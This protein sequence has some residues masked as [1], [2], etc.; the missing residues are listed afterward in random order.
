MAASAPWPAEMMACE[1]PVPPPVKELLGPHRSE[2]GIEPGGS[3]PQSPVQGPQGYRSESCRCEQVD[4]DEA[5]PLAHEP[6]PLDEPQQFL[7]SFF[8]GGGQRLKQR[9]EFRAIPQV[10]AG[11]LPDDEGVPATSASVSSSDKAGLPR[12][13]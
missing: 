13:R 4:V 1:W 2:R 11:Q 5:K 12:R 8:R 10:P 7:V 6:V 9:E 3:L